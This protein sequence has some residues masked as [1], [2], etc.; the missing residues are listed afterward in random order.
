L[1]A[2]TTTDRA[3]VVAVAV[4]WE[5]RAL[6]T[7]QVKVVQVLDPVF[8]EQQHTTQV[9]AVAVHITVTV[10]PAEPAAVEQGPESKQ[11]VE[12]VAQIQVAVQVLLVI[13]AVPAVQVLLEGR[14]L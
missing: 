13:Q 14:V 6:E 7:L 9:A 2:P 11:P 12:T 5:C 1:A 4:A 8:Q 3:A 10:A